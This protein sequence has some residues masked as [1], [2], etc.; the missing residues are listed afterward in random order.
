MGRFMSPD[1]S[2]YPNAVPYADLG[3]PQSLNLYRYAANNP[4]RFRDA[5]GHTHQDCSKSSSSSTDSDGTIHVTVTEHCVDVPDW[6]NFGTRFMNWRQKQA[7]AWNARIDAHR[8][9]P[10]KTDDTLAALQAITD[11][12]TIGTG[13]PNAR[14]A[15][16]RLNKLNH[17]FDPKHNLEPLVREFGSQEGAMQAIEKAASEQ[18]G[19]NIGGD[20]QI[21]QVG[22]YNVTVTGGSSPAGPQ[23]GNAWIPGPGQAGPP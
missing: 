3:D 15:A 16:A 12:M 21:I 2:E 20:S 1:W 23:V 11:A 22:Q 6:W 18:L 9:P 7:D 4:L 5:S 8:A 19:S 17:V 10:Q 14:A 13:L